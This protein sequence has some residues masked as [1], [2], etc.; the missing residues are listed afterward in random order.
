MKEH[1]KTT[2]LA[3]WTASPY[4][5][6]QS[7]NMTTKEWKREGERGSIERTREGRTSACLRLNQDM[8]KNGQND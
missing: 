3:L 5:T 8:A 2:F 1:E 4:R 7:G 6:K